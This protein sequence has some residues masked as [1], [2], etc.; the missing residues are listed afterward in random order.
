MNE[1]RQFNNKFKSLNTLLDDDIKTKKDF[2]K[3]LKYIYVACSR[4][5]EVLI[6][7]D[8]LNQYHNTNLV[9]LFLKLVG[10]KNGR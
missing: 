7:V 10:D 8:D 5:R 9:S 4:A 6:V 2:I 1:S 3:N